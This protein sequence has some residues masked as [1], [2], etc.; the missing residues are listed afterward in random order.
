MTDQT[1]VGGD[2][3]RSV[4]RDSQDLERK[5]DPLTEDVNEHPLIREFIDQVVKENYGEV[6]FNQRVNLFDL[7]LTPEQG[8]RL[9]QLL[10]QIC[11][12]P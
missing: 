2:P 6:T 7:N 8:E 1:T 9:I 12:G 4:P 11:V 3:R 10:H 5:Q